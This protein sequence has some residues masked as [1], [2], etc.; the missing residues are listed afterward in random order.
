MRNNNGSS[1]PSQEPEKRYDGWLR[2]LRSNKQS[3]KDSPITRPV[4]QG[5]DLRNESTGEECN[6][7]R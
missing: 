5:V 2:W 6:S 1:L 7:G 4:E 3:R